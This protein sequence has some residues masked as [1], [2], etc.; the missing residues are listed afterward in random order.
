MKDNLFIL[1]KTVEEIL[2][3]GRFCFL[4]LLLLSM[5]EE[6]SRGG[7]VDEIVKHEIICPQQESLPS[8]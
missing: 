8:M 2:G 7:Q 4:V 5:I 1:I 3:E 6:V